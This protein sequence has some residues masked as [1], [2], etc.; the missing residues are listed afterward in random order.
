[1]S[2]STNP[3]LDAAR[4]TDALYSFSEAVDKAEQDLAWD[5]AMACKAGDVKAEADF[6]PARTDYTKRTPFEG[7][8]P[9]R[10]QTLA[11]VLFDS[12]DYTDGPS[13]DD[14]FAVLLRVANEGDK[15]AAELVSRM[16]KKWA[17]M[18]VGEVM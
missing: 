15:Q 11:E 4:H 10:A 9:V 17:S 5:Y 3:V 7:V 2:Y 14:V 13:F 18:N 6:A 8:Y 1:M 12:L 16:G